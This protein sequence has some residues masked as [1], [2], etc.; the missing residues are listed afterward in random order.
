M[1]PF[2]KKYYLFCP[3][4]PKSVIWLCSRNAPHGFYLSVHPKAQWTRSTRDPHHPQTVRA[5][6]GGQGRI[7]GEQNLRALLRPNDVGLSLSVNPRERRG[8]RGLSVQ[9]NSTDQQ[10]EDTP[11]LDGE[12]KEGGQWPKLPPAYHP[13]SP[14]PAPQSSHWA[15]C[16]FGPCSLN[17]PALGAE[18]ILTPFSSP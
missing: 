15:P 2:F 10:L 12:T 8:R 5:C 16:V 7:K 3:S 17:T 18:S 13:F 4:L 14:D 11:N 1:H 6:P 9:T